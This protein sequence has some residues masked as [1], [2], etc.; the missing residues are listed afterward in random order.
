MRNTTADFASR[1]SLAILL[2]PE[3]MEKLDMRDKAIQPERLMSKNLW[4]SYQK[5]NHS[6]TVLVIISIVRSKPHPLAG[7]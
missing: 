1:S 6:I 2:I 7:V 5:N 4:D 3:K